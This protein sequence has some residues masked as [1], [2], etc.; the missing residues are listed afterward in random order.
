MFLNEI[1]SSLAF[2]F[3]RSLHYVCK[4]IKIFVNIKKKKKHSILI[5]YQRKYQWQVTDNLSA[6][7]RSKIKVSLCVA[8]DKINILALPSLNS[9]QKNSL[10]L[11][12]SHEF[13]ASLGKHIKKKKSV[14]I[15]HVQKF[16][17]T[18]LVLIT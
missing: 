13:D 5:L 11:D 10:P 15:K 14:H 9:L 1:I 8:Q 7:S 2:L 17:V 16:W 12:I 6:I 18:Y 4:T 3:C